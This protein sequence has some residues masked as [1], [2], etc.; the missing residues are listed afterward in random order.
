[1]LVGVQPGRSIHNPLSSPRGATVRTNQPS[2]AFVEGVVSLT[3]T[4]GGVLE[5]SVARDAV[6]CVSSPPH[7]ASS[8]IAEAAIHP[9]KKRMRLR[10]LSES[11]LHEFIGTDS[12]PRPAPVPDGPRRHRAYS[13]PAMTPARYTKVLGF[14]FGRPLAAGFSSTGPARS[15]GCKRRLCPS[16]RQADAPRSK[17]RISWRLPPPPPRDT[18]PSERP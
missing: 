12:S 3:T 11:D 8:R 2:S 1:M 15:H 13:P 4:F 18:Q 14:I 16:S 9:L 7:P 6:D 17:V 10:F 5:I